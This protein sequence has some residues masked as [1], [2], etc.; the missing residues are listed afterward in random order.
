LVLVS[1]N[2]VGYFR[3]IAYVAVGFFF[4][5]FCRDLLAR[6]L[7][8]LYD[9]EVRINL[10][11]DL[12]TTESLTITDTVVV[13]VRGEH[14]TWGL[15]K[16]LPR[17]LEIE[18]QEPR[19]IR[20]VIRFASLN[21]KSTGLQAYSGDDRFLLLM[22][23]KD[24][25][26]DHGRHTFQFQYETRGMIEQVSTGESL[27]LRLTRG[28]LSVPIQNARVRLMLPEGLN[29]SDRSVRAYHV[30]RNKRLRLIEPQRVSQSEFVVRTS[31]IRP[32][33]DL[34]FQARW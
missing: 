2:R 11:S 29:I 9:S 28:L 6:E 15:A 33:E 34:L 16:T 22:G 17:F 13:Q 19:R 21:D 27:D 10:A 1:L 14:F 26:L 7:I 32:G 20:Y 12:V 4:I 31:D 5:F 23:Q 30:A 24:R 18:G 3:K 25:E 8:E